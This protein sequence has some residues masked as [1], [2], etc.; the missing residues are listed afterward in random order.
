MTA[1][2]MI[3]KY[4]I[5]LNNDGTIRVM[6]KNFTQA[7][8]ADIKAKK[9]EIVAELKKMAV[10]EEERKAVKEASKLAHIENIKSGKE[11][12]TVKWNDG[13]YLQ[14]YEVLGEEAKLLEEIGLAEYV[15]GWGYYIKSEIID[16]LGES[17]SYQQAVEY[18]RPAN[19][20]KKAAQEKKEAEKAAK[21]AEAKETGKPVE[22]KRYLADC[23]GTVEECSTDIVTVYAMPDGSTKTKRTHTF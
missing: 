23:D 19:E 9:P 22:L 6:G 16:K 8:V 10:A 20:A 13:E 11:K 7:E 21:F 2:E 14:G 15:S 12:I 4:S 1:Q 17:F 5:T 3:K 18:M